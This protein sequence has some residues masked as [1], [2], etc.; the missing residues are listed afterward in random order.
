MLDNG[1]RE[2]GATLEAI[3]QELG[4]SPERVRQIEFR[5]LRKCR[6]WC[7]AHGWRFEDL[8]PAWPQPERDRRLSP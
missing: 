7:L 2:D 8:V 4:I 3:A 1:L 5:A 6:A